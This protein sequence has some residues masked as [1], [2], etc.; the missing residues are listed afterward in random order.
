MGAPCG[1]GLAPPVSPHPSR[2]SS[3]RVMSPIPRPAGRQAQLAA[4]RDG[5]ESV[6]PAPPHGRAQVPGLGLGDPAELQQVHAGERLPCPALSPS[7][8]A[9]AARGGRGRGWCR[10]A[11]A[12]GVR[13]HVP[14]G[15]GDQALW[16]R[17]HR[18]TLLPD[19]PCGPGQPFP[20]PDGAVTVAPTPVSRSGPGLGGHAVSGA[21]HP[22]RQSARAKT[23]PA[24]ALW[25]PGGGWVPAASGARGPSGGRLRVPEHGLHV[26]SRE[27]GWR[28]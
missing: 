28:L 26:G 25:R 6:L 2:P 18:A 12:S 23:R 27:G 20:T 19:P 8:L 3:A 4:A 24:Y 11:A 7:P 15:L 16:P 21:R 5:G 9:G 14:Q 22:P 10:L 13:R 17:V 1:L